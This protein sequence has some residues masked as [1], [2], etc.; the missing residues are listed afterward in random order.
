L[1]LQL[2]LRD[3][4]FEIDDG[5][6]DS[7]SNIYRIS[8]TASLNRVLNIKLMQEGA[9]G[10]NITGTLMEPHV[11]PIVPSETQAALKP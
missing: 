1:S 8:G 3:G 9:Q 7:L 4:K 5:K 11:S 2:V 6:L 10:F